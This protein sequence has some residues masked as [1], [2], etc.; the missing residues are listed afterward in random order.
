MFYICY[1]EV[2]QMLQGCYRCYTSSIYASH[3]KLNV[4]ML[5]HFGLKRAQKRKNVMFYIC[6]SDVTQMLH[7]CYKDV[8]RMLQMLR[9]HHLCI[10]FQ[11]QCY[12]VTAFWAETGAET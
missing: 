10:A 11:T 4:T 9:L 8:T 12:N 7:G 2:T 1:S 3:F 5:Q 6:Y